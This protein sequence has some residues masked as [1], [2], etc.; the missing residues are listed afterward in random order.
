VAE[1]PELHAAIEASAAGDAVHKNRS[2][3]PQVEKRASAEKAVSE[4]AKTLAPG[5]PRL[6][7]QLVAK[8]FPAVHRRWL[9][10]ET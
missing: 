6:G 1:T 8:H 10:T 4:L 2:A 5:D 7:M 3:N 9:G